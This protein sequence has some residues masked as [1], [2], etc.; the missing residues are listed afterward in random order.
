MIFNI[1]YGAL[2]YVCRHQF[3]DFKSPNLITFVF[4]FILIFMS[5]PILENDQYRYLWEG[6]VLMGGENPYLS[7]PDSPLLDHIKFDARKLVGFP[8]LTTVYPPVALIWFSIAS[9]FSGFYKVGLVIL[10][11]M[12]SILVTYII[13][14]LSRSSD[15]GWMLVLVFPLFLKEY[16]QS[17]HID[18]LAFFWCFLF[19][20][21]KD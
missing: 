3:K 1:I 5:F 15:K 16:V 11:F 21:K 12:N 20:I 14:R 6:R 8:S 7:A 13:M 4:S 19:L 18:L 17:V 9:F 2:V 10:M